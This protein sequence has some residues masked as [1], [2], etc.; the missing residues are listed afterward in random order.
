MKLR[1]IAHSR[2]GDKGNTSNLSLIAYDP[3]D[4]PQLLQLGQQLEDFLLAEALDQLLTRVGAVD[5]VDQLPA[6]LTGLLD[7]DVPRRA[8]A[9]QVE[10]PIWGVELLRCLLDPR[11][12]HRRAS[13]WI[14]YR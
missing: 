3:R 14:G 7:V 13:F 12:F 6:L 2:A 9:Q 8:G 11:S 10:V 5:R 4:Y 1:E